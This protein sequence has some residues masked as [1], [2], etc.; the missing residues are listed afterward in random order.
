MESFKFGL[1]ADTQFADRP[2]SIGR[3][4]RNALVKTRKAVDAFLREKVEFC[5]HLGDV[6]DWPNQP[7]KALE[8][9]N[10]FIPVMK[11]VGAP[12]HYVIGNHDLASVR[13]DL[14]T[15]GLQEGM[16]DT[17]YSFDHKGM[18]FIILDCNF[19][20][21][22]EWYCPENSEWDKCYIPLI[23][24]QWLE[25]DLAATQSPYVFVFVHALLDD[26]DNPHVIRNAGDVRRILEQ[27]GKHII[28]FQGHMHSGHE[29]E[30]N[31]IGYHT[32]KAIVDG[33]THLCYWI[34]EVTGDGIYLDRYDNQ[35]NH[36]KAK[37]ECMFHYD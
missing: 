14:F 33:R 11:G 27:S 3:Y 13:V 21:N 35:V 5:V 16:K 37:R 36:G 12:V 34:V 26:M 10:Q 22:S 8:A 2:K 17:W 31:G 9:L 15:A 30:K 20:N 18:H 28:V 29:S 7:E 19:D 32:M 4:Y 25:K 23:E 24:Q 6:I 1:I